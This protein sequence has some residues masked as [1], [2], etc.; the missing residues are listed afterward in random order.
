MEEVAIK[1]IGRTHGVRL[2][3]VENGPLCP[4]GPCETCEYYCTT[5]RGVEDGVIEDAA[6]LMAGYR[7]LSAICDN[8]RIAVANVRFG[9]DVRPTV[10]ELNQM[11]RDRGGTPVRPRLRVI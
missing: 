11:V 10:R 1:E 4:H 6:Q 7:P 5:R 8:Q 3:I 2:F 9:L